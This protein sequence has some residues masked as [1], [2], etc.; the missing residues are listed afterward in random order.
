MSGAAE[1]RSCFCGLR[2]ALSAH[3]SDETLRKSYQDERA[4][5]EELFESQPDVPVT[6]DSLAGFLNGYLLAAIQFATLELIEQRNDGMFAVIGGIHLLGVEA[7]LSCQPAQLD[8]VKAGFF[9]RLSRPLLEYLPLP[10]ARGER[11]YAAAE[12]VIRGIFGTTPDVP[13]NA[14]SLAGFVLGVMYSHRYVPTDG[15]ELAAIMVAAYLVADWSGS[16]SVR[17]DRP[18]I[19]PQ[20]RTR[21]P[22]VG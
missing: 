17:D 1:T 9:R 16:E 8:A 11:Q 7:P 6:Q 20:S 19:I 2:E 14:E 13:V 15:E 21:R 5:I 22:G 3:L 18:G 10:P 12:Q 4:L